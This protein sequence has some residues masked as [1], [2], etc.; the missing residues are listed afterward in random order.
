MGVLIV[1]KKRKFRYVHHHHSQPPT[2]TNS[3]PN[4]PHKRVR[5]R[6]VNANLG[7]NNTRH[8]DKIYAYIESRL[9]PTKPCTFGKKRGGGKYGIVHEGPIDVPVRHFRLRYARW[10][11]ETCRVLIEHGD[12]LQSHCTTC[13]DRYRAA[14]LQT[15]SRRFQG[16]TTEQIYERYHHVYGKVSKT[17]SQCKLEK[18]VHHFIISRRMECGLHNICR[19][20][21][22]LQS[23]VRD[24]LI[25]YMPDGAN[26][27]Y[28]KS[29]EKAGLHDDHIFPL[30]LG[31]TNEASNHQLLSPNENLKKSN[32]ISHF[33]GLME[34]DP[35]LLS[36]RFR[37]VLEKATD[38]FHLRILLEQ[39]MHND[40]LERY[41]MSNSELEE[42]Y[43]HYFETHN[44]RHSVKRAVQKF[45]EFCEMKWRSN[46]VIFIT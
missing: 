14:R 37:H 40:I 16:L 39:A 18:G 35:C 15:C 23:K 26:Y 25:M 44:L 20:C 2:P 43:R 12:G 22:S 27:K 33:E 19:G 6:R 9:G 29:D 17:C 10:E 34:I 41:G 46:D 11:E 36:S 24:R 45:R 30:S 3:T 4:P 38:M 31:G 21:S 5:Q 13:D 42:V 32:G 7:R 28:K 1:H 8:H